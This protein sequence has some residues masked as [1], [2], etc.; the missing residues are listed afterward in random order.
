MTKGEAIERL[1]L[2]NTK[3]EELSEHSFTKKLF[4]EPSGVHIN[5][6]KMGTDGRGTMTVLRMGPDGDSWKAFTLIFRLFIFTGKGR[7]GELMINFR[8]LPEIY[9]ALPQTPKFVQIAQ[10]VDEVIAAYDA[11]MSTKINEGSNV[12]LQFGNTDE[13]TYQELV[14]YFLY[15]DDFHMDDD[16]RK[17]FTEWQQNP[18]VFKLLENRFV[19]AVAHIID[20]AILF[21]RSLNKLALKELGAA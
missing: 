17:V 9:K 12:R 2:Y 6:D 13:L 14:D 10:K 5:F 16:K 1:R 7:K 21:I 15:S 19:E 8:N 20:E 11:S 18:L 4:D 3:A